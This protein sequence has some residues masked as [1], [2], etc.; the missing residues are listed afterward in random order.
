MP[1][2]ILVADDDRTLNDLVREQLQAQGYECLQAFDGAEAKALFDSEALDAMVLAV[3]LPDIPGIEV[4]LHVKERCPF[5]SVMVLTDSANIKKDTHLLDLGADAVFSKPLVGDELVEG[6]SQ[7]ISHSRSEREVLERPHWPG[8]GVD[9][10]M[11]RLFLNAPAA[12]I[13]VD[14]ANTIRAVNRVAAKLLGSR[15]EFILGRSIL[16]IVGTQVT[17]QWLDVVRSDAATPRGYEGE[18]HLKRGEGYLFPAN[19]MAVERLDPGHLIFSVRDLAQE[20]ELELQLVQTKKLASLGKVV[21]GVAHEVRNPLIAIGGFARKMRRDSDEG[22]NES[23]YLDIILK[24]VLRLEAMVNDIEQY[25]DFASS[26]AHTFRS[27]NLGD[28]VTEAFNASKQS[29]PNTEDV[30]A[31]IIVPEGTPDVHGDRDLLLKLFDA[32]MENAY[33]AMPDGGELTVQVGFIEG[34][35]RVHVT[36]TGVGIDTSQMEEVFDPFYTSKTTGAGLGLAKAY[37]VCEDHGGHIYLESK[38]GEGTTCTVI[39]PI[40]RRQIER[41]EL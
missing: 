17:A 36:D 35:V 3:D 24:E 9:H 22:S 31:T 26:H 32:L 8:E 2:R 27:E 14:P 4:L 23:Q 41:K 34:W 11:G 21:E 1:G 30:A 5:I 16:D 13:H 33:H 25:V 18:L 28:I 39:L 37:M 40:D 38:L 6:L 29:A 7:K 15:P 19:I 12:L 10:W 20:K